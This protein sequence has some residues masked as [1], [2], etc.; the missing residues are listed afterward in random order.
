T[1]DIS[2]RSGDLEKLKSHPAYDKFMKVALLCNNGSF[3]QGN[4]KP[5]S[6]GDP[7]EVALLRMAGKLKEDTKA[8]Q[9]RHERVAELRF[10]SQ[11]KMM[12]T[13]NRVDDAY[14]ICVKGAAE[15]VLQQCNRIM[16]GDATTDLNDHEQWK[17]T[18]NDMADR[19]LR[20]LGFAYRLGKEN[21]G[22]ENI[23]HDLVFIGLAGFID[24]AR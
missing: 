13:V 18:A 7:E 15:E 4:G 21:P 24:P 14:M 10:D 12:A 5:K 20:V 6:S 2:D 1:T 11:I 19:G 3:E 9:H 16:E 23:I 17:A 8:I 22:K